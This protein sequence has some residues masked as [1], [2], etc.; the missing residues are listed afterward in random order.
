MPAYT[1][2][3]VDEQGRASRGTVEAESPRAARGQLRGR[4]LVPLAVTVVSQASSAR[5]KSVL[6]SELWSPRAFPATQLTVLTRQLAGLV[7]AGLPLEKALS[8][9]AEEA[10]LPRQQAVL[11]GLRAEVNAGASLA[12]AL[13]Q[14]PREFSDTYRAVIAAGEQGGSLGQVLERL[15]QEQEEALALRAKLVGAA[16]Y[17]AIVSLIAL[18]IV[19]FLLAYVVP[20]VAEVFTGQK[21]ALPWLTQTMLWLSAQVRSQGGL[22]LLALA[23]AA[24]AARVALKR[25]ALRLAFD[26]AWLKLPLVGRL[27]RSYHAARF[28][29]TLALLTGAGVPMLKALQ[30]A[31]DTLGNRAMRADAEDCLSLVREG[32]P[33]AS[34]LGRHPRFPG[35]LVMFARLGEQTG[36]LPDMLQRAAR[37]LSEEVQR[38]ALRMATLLE[39]LL[40]VAM[41]AMVMLIV[42]AVLL[43]I[44]E[45]NQLAR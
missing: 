15:A 42:L 40:I 1:Y 30:A 25:P 8:V 31:T 18:A 13:A 32:A 34:A 11:A 20:Q 19:V 12:K 24:V 23:G 45:L 29:S 14:F 6:Q 10:E 22:M 3:A 17:P 43:P 5:P 38:R 21:R 44:I 16:L 36:T 7:G 4:G 9:L 33:L 37:Q 41:G 2:E 26:A 27:S 39:P 35:L 28:G